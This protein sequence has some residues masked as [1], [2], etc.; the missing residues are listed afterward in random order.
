MH[1]LKRLITGLILVF[2]LCLCMATVALAD[3]SGTIT[4]DCVR[5]RTQASSDSEVYQQLNKGDSVAVLGTDE[6]GWVKISFTY[7]EDGSSKTGYVSQDYITVDS[8][9]S[10][11]EAAP[12]E[13]SAPVEETAPEESP[14]DVET[15][16]EEPEKEP[17]AE[18]TVE[19]ETSQEETSTITVNAGQ[20]SS[21]VSVTATVTSTVNLREEAS[22]ESQVLAELPE[23]GIV[24]VLGEE[25]ADGWIPVK[26]FDS[27]GTKLKGYVISSALEPNLIGK[28]VSNTASA[29][30]RTE[31][32]AS[33]EM[34]GVIPE[35]GKVSI[36]ESR[37]GMYRVEYEDLT[38]WVDASCIDVE[39]DDDCYGYGKVTVDG[40]RLRAERSTDS[41]ILANIDKGTVLQLIKLK[42]DWY[43]T[44]Y[45]GQE[46]QVSAEFVDVVDNGEGGYIQV[47][48][49][50]LYLRS[51][52]GKDYAAL[53]SIPGGTVL[54][55][56]GSVGAWYVVTYG[57]FTG[58]VCGDYVSATGEG[59]FTVNSDGSTETNAI[60][61][62]A[63]SLNL[64]AK[65]DINSEKLASLSYGT[66]LEILSE[67][68][69]W[70]KVSCGGTVGYVSKEYTGTASASEEESV[71]AVA[72]TSGNASALSYASQFVGNRY[73]WGGTSLTNGCDCSGFVMSVFA[74]YG[75]SLP[76]SSSAI[77]NYGKSVSYS[78][79]QPG[80]VV[81][82]SGHVGIY[83]GNG[84]LLSAL[85][86]NK[87]ITY[88][89]VNY[90]KIITIRRML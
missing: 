11:E 9:S 65:P 24:F 8:A 23:G 63:S 12:A 27:E 82:Y 89:S 79:M 5:V 38:G 28:G 55:T 40:L 75:V 10:D 20:I 73:V 49:S 78:D 47:T 70:Y 22:K 68:N 13:E 71:R 87:G 90:K 85:N 41:D 7:N 16:K 37:D 25:S 15:P 30:V 81:C 29:I 59:G 34:A 42:N 83:A 50:S 88:C 17:V 67:E 54:E 76:H 1:K 51:G 6:Y 44:V 19:S 74:Q 14:A 33:A 86:K 62:T 26:Y 39:S 56:K 84:Q 64:R 46:G 3:S 18:E 53:A 35:D 21:D 69:G 66:E 80:D 32:D 52:A 72:S 2:S 31:A 43:K 58:F 4:A 61:V 45:N 36:Y 60:I 57:K 48:A 77:R